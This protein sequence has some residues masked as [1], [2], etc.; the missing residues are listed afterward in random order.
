M[1]I[2]CSTLAFRKYGLTEALER[3]RAL[4]FNTVELCA[5]SHHSDP[6][7]W[8]TGRDGL[9]AW[10]HRLGLKVSSVHVPL[11]AERAI[12]AKDRDQ[13]ELKRSFRAVETAVLLQGEF[14]V[15]HLELLADHFAQDEQSPL[16]STVP[17]LSKVLRRAQEKKVKVAVENVPS[18]SF[19]MFGRSVEE[20]G[21]LLQWIPREAGGLCLDLTHCL[22]CGLDPMEILERIDPSRLISIHASDNISAPWADRHLPLGEGTIPWKRL[23]EYLK[24]AGFEGP[25]VIEV[26]DEKALMDSLQYLAS[27]HVLGLA[28]LP[29][30]RASP[31]MSLLEKEVK[32]GLSRRFF[33]IQSA[34]LTRRTRK[35]TSK[36]E[37]S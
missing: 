8:N 31:S 6:E 30:R 26:F 3:V 34:S 1:Q 28:G 29:P 37:C 22:A 5:N 2:V 21:H 23:F 25:I 36:G 17:N 18:D 35:N 19:P 13:E 7:R 33:E 9:M 11:E 4:G 10:V 12:F 20:I 14:I 27:L 24:S 15:Q 16:R 32:E